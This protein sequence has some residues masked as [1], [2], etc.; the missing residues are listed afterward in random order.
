MRSD[1]EKKVKKHK[2]EID[3]YLNFSI[4]CW[5]NWTIFF[6]QSIKQMFRWP[7]VRVRQDVHLPRTEQ[8][9]RLPDF[10]KNLG[11]TLWLPSVPGA[12]FLVPGFC[13]TRS[14]K[15]WEDRHQD[16]S[17]P[18]LTSNCSMFSLDRVTCRKR[19]K[20][21]NRLRKGVYQGHIKKSTEL[22]QCVDFG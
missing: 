13:Q 9:S 10:N 6:F 11:L 2:I 14:P 1:M 17:C 19:S 5:A 3:M 8:S 16:L 20:C 18:I 22:N 15:Y 12:W 7:S 21:A 4:S